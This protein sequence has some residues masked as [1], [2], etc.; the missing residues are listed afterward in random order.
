V[1]VDVDGD[2]RQK[3]EHRNALGHLAARGRLP[4]SPSELNDKRRDDHN[5]DAVGQ[6]PHAPDG[7][8]WRSGIEQDR[9]RGTCCG[10]RGGGHTGE[11]KKAGDPRQV[12]KRERPPKPALKQP[13]HEDSLAGAADASEH[14]GH[15]TLV[16]HGAGSKRARHKANNERWTYAPA[17][18][19]QEADSDSGH[20]A[21]R[22]HTGRPRQQ[23]QPEFRHEEKDNG[24]KTGP[25]ERGR[26][27]ASGGSR[28]PA[29]SMRYVR[30]PQVTPAQ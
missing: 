17:E 9:S 5:A 22:G 24:K 8:K 16:A 18:D 27:D 11:R 23:C 10:A 15:E 29:C 26:P 14:R 13:G 19:N 2:R 25:A 21:E 6:E 20:G 12:R 28:A 7:P 4:P 3:R 1:D 30:F